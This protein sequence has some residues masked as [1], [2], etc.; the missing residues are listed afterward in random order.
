MV[1]PGTGLSILGAGIGSAKILEKMLGPT[2]DYIGEGIKTWTEKRIT[3]VNNIFSNAQRKLGDKIDSDGAVPPKVLKSILDEGSFCD[4]ELSTEYF[5]GVLAS[6]RSDVPRDDRGAALVALIARLSTYQLRAHYIFYHIIKSLFDG[7]DNSPSMGDGRYKLETYIPFDT[8]IINMEFDRKE[9]ENSWIILQHVL[10]GLK[11]EH[12]IGPDFYY[13]KQEFLAKHFK[14]APDG[15]IVFQPSSMGT[16]LFCWAHGK[17]NLEDVEFLKPKNK[18]R[19][20][21]NINIRSGY[22]KT[23]E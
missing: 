22:L 10:F 6:S 3:N 11:K 2:A 12:L 20:Q 16:E 17:P 15:G 9:K 7:T 8:F 5:G 23:K 19:L 18:F 13:G 4:D 21:S 1:D 14:K